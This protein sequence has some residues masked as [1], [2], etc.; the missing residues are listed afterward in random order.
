MHAADF[1]AK[2][3]ESVKANPAYDGKAIRAHHWDLSSAELPPE[4]LENSID[5]ITSIF[6]L[7]ALHPT[8]FRQ[9]IINIHKVSSQAKSLAWNVRSTLTSL[10]APEAGRH[11]P[12]SRFWAARFMSI[13]F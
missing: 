12:V 6:V 7:S 9:A 10:L 11:A 2:A 13:T 1:S 4:L 3:I 5:M 8:E